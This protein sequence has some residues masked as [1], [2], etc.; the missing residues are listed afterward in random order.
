LIKEQ[1]AEN[2]V[3]HRNSTPFTEGGID[4]QLQGIV[5]G[6]MTETGVFLTAKGKAFSITSTASSGGVKRIIEMVLNIDK[7]TFEYWKEY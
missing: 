1:D 7:N 3:N 5:N 6:F 2:I 4:G